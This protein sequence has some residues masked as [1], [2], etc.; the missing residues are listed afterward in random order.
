M[1]YLKNFNSA[2]SFLELES[3]KMVFEDAKTDSKGWFHIEKGKLSAIYAKNNSAFLMVEDNVYPIHYN[4]TVKLK[5]MDNSTTATFEL[6]N[7]YEKVVYFDY[8]KDEKYNINSPFEYLDDE[9]FD[10]GLFLYNIINS[11]ERLE[12][13]IENNS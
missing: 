13:F 12:I 11:K 4:T 9:D 1:S 3:K 5:R 2:T 8:T 10:W 7:D 6:W